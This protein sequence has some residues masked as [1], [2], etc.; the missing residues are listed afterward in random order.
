MIF[1]HVKQ[2]QLVNEHMVRQMIRHGHE[3]ILQT[4][5]VHLNI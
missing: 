5:F 3:N 1:S 2:G 4:V